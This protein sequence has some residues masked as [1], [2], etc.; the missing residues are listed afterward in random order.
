MGNWLRENWVLGLIFIILLILNFNIFNDLYLSRTPDLIVE[1]IKHRKEGDTWQVK[2]SSTR[3]HPQGQAEVSIIFQDGTIKN[4]AWSLSEKEKVWE[5]KSAPVEAVAI[6]S[7]GEYDTYMVNSK[8]RFSPFSEPVHIMTFGKNVTVNFTV[9]KDDELYA[10]YSE[11][12]KD[13]SRQGI[14]LAKYNYRGKMAGG[15]HLISSANFTS[16]VK[17]IIHLNEGQGKTE[18]LLAWNEGTEDDSRGKLVYV[19]AGSAD[20]PEF[21]IKNLPL[22]P[23]GLEEGSQRRLIFDSYY[24]E[25]S[26]YI[27][28]QAKGEEGFS[29]EVLSLDGFTIESRLTAPGLPADDEQK[30]NY[31]RIIPDAEGLNILWIQPQNWNYVLRY[32]KIAYSGEVLLPVREISN[33]DMESSVAEPVQIIRSK[34]GLF[35]VASIRSVRGVRVTRQL[36]YLLIDEEGNVLENIRKFMDVIGYVTGFD[37]RP[38]ANGNIELYYSMH[39]G[40]G[41]LQPQ[42]N[43]EVYRIQYNQKLEAIA[44]VQRIVSSTYFDDSPVVRLNPEGDE[45]IFWKQNKTDATVVNYMTDDQALVGELSGITTLGWKGWLGR[46]FEKYSYSALMALFFGF[47][48]SLLPVLGLLVFN[49]YDRKQHLLYWISAALLMF[50]LKVYVEVNLGASMISKMRVSLPEIYQFHLWSVFALLLF[51]GLYWLSKRDKIRSGLMNKAIL[52]W[53]F[54]DYFAIFALFL[55]SYFIV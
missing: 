3:K 24:A 9:N 30:V 12:Q 15:P 13:A 22:V 11:F 55:A 46:K 53:Y 33:L 23:A 48:F 36:D 49:R 5:F 41:F 10:V 44:P 6:K 52:I 40:S 20:A 16:G 37:I 42:V 43:T 51:T 14:Y 45:F 54:L 18:I 34:D 2:V 28:V 21:Q 31:A 17:P 50:F 38:L 47:V 32:E 4:E 26:H 35:H 8:A 7:P 1:R 25:N 29:W 27:L 39:T 19:T